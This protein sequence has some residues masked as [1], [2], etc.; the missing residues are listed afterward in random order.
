MLRKIG[1]SRDCAAASASCPHGYQST[2]LCACCNRYGLISLIRRFGTLLLPVYAET[3]MAPALSLLSPGNAARHSVCFALGPLPE[4]RLD[5]FQDKDA[6]A[7]VAGQTG[8][9]ALG[10]AS[11]EQPVGKCLVFIQR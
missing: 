8:R 1:T 3:H 7:R 4:R 11:F 2:G 9:V 5:S 10:N 6:L